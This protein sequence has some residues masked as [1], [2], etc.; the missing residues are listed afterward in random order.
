VKGK[1]EGGRLEHNEHSVCFTV[2]DIKE[3]HGHIK[4]QQTVQAN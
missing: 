4:S 3:R 2:T 1:R